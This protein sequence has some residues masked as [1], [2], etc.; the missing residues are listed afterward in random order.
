MM[1]YPAILMISPA[2]YGT[3]KNKIIEVRQQVLT[4]EDNES[5]QLI[6]KTNPFILHYDN[7]DS[8]T[9]AIPMFHQVIVDATLDGTAMYILDYEGD[10]F[11][12]IKYLDK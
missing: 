3:I 12:Y 4:S 8:K 6:I 10:V 7:T 11:T 9:V 1:L 5:T 2:R